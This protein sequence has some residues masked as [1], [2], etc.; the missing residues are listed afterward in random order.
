MKKVDPATIVK[1]IKRF[2]GEDTKVIHELRSD[3]EIPNYKTLVF[4]IDTRYD[5]EETLGREKRMKGFM[6]EQFD[7]IPCSFIYNFE[8]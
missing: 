3:P 6:I 7:D 2:F 5:V 4:E 1:V 8:G